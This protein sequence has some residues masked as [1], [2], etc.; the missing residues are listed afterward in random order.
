MLRLVTVC[1]VG[2]GVVMGLLALSKAERRTDNPSRAVSLREPLSAE[3]IDP[4]ELD[5]GEAWAQPAFRW[6]V[7]LR[8]PTVQPLEVR[9]VQ[10]G[11]ACTSV[12]PRSATVQPGSSCELQLR[13]NLL[14]AANVESPRDF[15]VELAFDCGNDA[16]RTAVLRGRVIAS[17]IGV[18]WKQLDLGEVVN[19]DPEVYRCS[20]PLQMRSADL[21][22]SA[23]C[24][25]SKARLSL[26]SPPNRDGLTNLEV[27]LDHSLP[28]GRFEIP[29]ILQAH[30]AS[31]VASKELLLPVRGEIV[32]DVEAVPRV[33]NL[34]GQPVGT[35]VVH[36]VTFQ[37]RTGRRIWSTAID[38]VPSGF[39]VEVMSQNKPSR[40]AVARIACPITK[41]GDQSAMLPFHFDVEAVDAPVTMAVPVRYNGIS[42]MSPE[43]KP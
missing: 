20:I 26:S 8:N 1:L 28:I 15:A 18:D 40:L 30:D 12:E 9:D 21:G 13:L 25:T 29:L 43:N 2:I 34:G 35:R 7:T 6:H 3:W 19:T 38:E 39:D 41:S 31:H 36:D 5:F 23:T 16:P 27:F 24:D 17:P 22:W 4:A 33:V 14:P 32:P 10:S 11:C 37:S 42:T